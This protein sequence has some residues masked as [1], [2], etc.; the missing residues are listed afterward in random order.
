[1]FVQNSCNFD[2]SKS[3]APLKLFDNI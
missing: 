2:Y 3:G 1:L